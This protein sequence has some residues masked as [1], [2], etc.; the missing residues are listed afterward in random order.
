MT[1]SVADRRRADGISAADPEDPPGPAGTRRVPPVD[2][3]HSLDVQRPQ[4]ASHRRP[5]A[6][7]TFGYS[8][9]QARIAEAASADMRGV[10]RDDRRSREHRHA[11][12]FDTR[13]S[14]CL[15]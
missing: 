8:P 12:Q 13:V 6:T 5:S 1:R 2:Y 4:G 15:L 14:K 11:R 7:S 9:P 10:R 3:R